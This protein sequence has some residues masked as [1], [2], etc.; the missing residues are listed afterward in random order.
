MAQ[1][2]REAMAPQGLADWILGNFK[3]SDLTH[4]KLQKLLFYCYGAAL[5]HDRSHE[6]G[7]VDFEAW[8]L[9]PVCKTVYHR[10]KVYKAAVIPAGDGDAPSYSQESSRILNAVLEIYGPLKAESLVEETHR[11]EPW[12]TAYS[13]GEGTPIGVES[14]RAHF[15]RRFRPGNVL[16]PSVSFDAGSF[17]LDSIPIEP[18]WDL[19]SL[20]SH[21]QLARKRAAIG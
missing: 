7:P 21:L 15:S 2:E 6:I 17:K 1:D 14:L 13:L 12:I 19:F 16:P 20:A 3:G 5:A 9:G 10:F 11:E 4:L 8:R 18:F